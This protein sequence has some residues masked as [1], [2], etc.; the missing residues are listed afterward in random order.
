MGIRLGNLMR[1][2]GQVRKTISREPET[3]II[4][5]TIFAR[6][7]IECLRYASCIRGERFVLPE[8]TNDSIRI[9]ALHVRFIT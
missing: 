7:R 9:G 2:V 8:K 1:D 6:I 5:Q 4:F 3:P